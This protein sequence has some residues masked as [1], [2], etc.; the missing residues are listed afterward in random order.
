[1]GQGHRIP[2]LCAL[3]CALVVTAGCDG[4]VR[5]P[6]ADG[7]VPVD[8]GESPLDVGESRLDADPLSE[9][10]VARDFGDEPPGG[11]VELKDGVLR[12]DGAP[13]TIRGVGWNPVAIGGLHPRDVDFAG[14]VVE[15]GD[16][17]R[18][19]G[20]NTVRTYE[21]IT[22]RSVLDALYTRGIYVLN[23]AYAWGGG[24][25]EA[26]RERVRAVADHPAILMWLVGN[27]WNY[28][29]L[30]VGLSHDDSLQR[31][32]DVIAVVRQEDP[33]HPIA[34]VYGELPNAETL[35]ALSEVDAWGINSYRGISFGD[36]FD[37]W[38]A[39]SSRPMFLAEYG[40]DA[41]NALLPGEDQQAQAD[42]TVALA[43]EIAG[44]AAA[45]N[46]GPCLGGALFEWAD[47]WW[48]DGSGD[49]RQQDVGG[50]APGG[51]PHPDRTFNEEWWGL[52]Q[53]DR[54]PRLA[55][56]ALVTLWGD[57]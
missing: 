51:G 30:Y 48:K 12:V 44:H 23:T 7:G 5:R 39:R 35:A 46:L 54:T 52:V 29:G 41:W 17:M 31:I 36:L 10:G 9:G 50:I 47:E 8:A 28:N 37:A 40:A 49:P 42:A 43:G 20:I 34:T 3:L 1:M 4:K 11:R 2:G 55:Y 6:R 22:D 15:D 53:I 14:H 32:K 19:A 38:S 27:E 24:T 57:P 25:A 21:T 45:T 13:F 26:V 16:L 18:A 33:L 56:Q